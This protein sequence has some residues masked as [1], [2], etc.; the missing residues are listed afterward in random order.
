MYNDQ[1]GEENEKTKVGGEQCS[2]RHHIRAT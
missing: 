2:W 1:E